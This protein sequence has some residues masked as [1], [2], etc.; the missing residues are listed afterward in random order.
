MPRSIAQLEMDLRSEVSQSITKWALRHSGLEAR[1][2]G[3]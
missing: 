1:F 3:E 2:M